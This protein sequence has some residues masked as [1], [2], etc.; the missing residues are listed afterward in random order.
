MRLSLLTALAMDLVE[1]KDK[2][3]ECSGFIGCKRL[4]HIDPYLAAL[5]PG[6]EGSLV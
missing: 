5:V 3:D 4:L 1:S 2:C 6:R